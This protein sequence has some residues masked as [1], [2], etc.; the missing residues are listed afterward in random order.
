MTTGE[1]PLLAAMRAASTMTSAPEISTMVPTMKAITVNTD[2]ASIFAEENELA[3]RLRMSQVLRNVCD[4]DDMSTAPQV[5]V[6][7]EAL[8]DLIVTDGGEVEAVCGGAPF[9]AARALG[10]LGVET[11]FIGATLKIHLVMTY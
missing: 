5:S 1:R 2:I 10:R 11:A 3:R 8:I 9:N 4:D 6:F 7:G